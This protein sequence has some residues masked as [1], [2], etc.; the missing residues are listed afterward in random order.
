L[1]VGVQ[2]E[3]IKS[4]TSSSS[5]N[6]VGL[7]TS[8]DGSFVVAFLEIEE[9]RQSSSENPDGLSDVDAA[10]VASASSEIKLSSY[11]LSSFFV[12]YSI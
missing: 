6:P 5:E 3:R 7:S 12:L 4:S 11:I 9:I 10:A 1:V 8:D 2:I